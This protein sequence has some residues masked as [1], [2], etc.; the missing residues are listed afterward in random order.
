MSPQGL[1]TRLPSAVKRWANRFGPRS[2]IST[3]ALRF[4]LLIVAVALISVSGSFER[5]RF[6]VLA[7]L[8]LSIVASL[9][10]RAWRTPTAA[11]VESAL[12]V[13]IATTPEPASGNLML[14]FIA[15]AVAAGLRGGYLWVVASTGTIAVLG[16]VQV[17]R[18]ESQFDEDGLVDL[19]RWSVLALA[20]GCMAT[21]YQRQTDRMDAVPYEEAVRVLTELQAISRRLPAGLD[22]GT[23]ASTALEEAVSISRADSGILVAMDANGAVDTVASHPEPN[24]P[25]LARLGNWDAWVDLAMLGVPAQRNTGEAVLVLCPLMVSDRLI[26]FALLSCSERLDRDSLDGLAATVQRNAVPLEAAVLFT[27]VRDIATNE[28]RSRIAR[29][30]HDGIAQD[31]A[32]LGYAAD[33]I[34]DL[35]TDEETRDLAEE[36]RR[37]ITRVVGELRMSVFTLREGVGPTETLAGTLGNHAR[38]IFR[39]SPVQVHLTVD[40]SPNRLRPEV[41]SEL[42]R[43]GQ[44]AL[45]NARRHASADNVWVT[46]IIDAPAATLVVEDDGIGLGDKGADS[47]GLEIMRERT[48]RIHAKLEVTARPGGGTVV[49]AII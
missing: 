13:I 21:W 38:R 16:V 3:S 30:I 49:R 1:A 24:H 5:V 29:E 23:I 33:E 20:A 43:I 36:L 10:F 6:A 34:V 8:A 45:N 37:Q 28:E 17:L 18:V 40:E 48:A 7:M 25:F 15:P 31:V 35:A 2:E 41:Q 44:E 27:G 9:P 32:F 47:Y 22:I 4:T 14:C 11:V 26:G 19:V 46:C 39:D 42:L 12:T